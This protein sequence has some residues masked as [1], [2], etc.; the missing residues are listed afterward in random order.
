MKKILRLTY[1]YLLR[2]LPSKL[3]S[4]IHYYLVYKRSLRLSSP[5]YFSE[6]MIRI[7][8]E[9]SRYLDVLCT[10]K[11]TSK[12]LLKELGYKDYIINNLYVFN[13]IDSIYIDENHYPVIIKISNGTS[14]NI[15]IRNNADLKL[16]LS[17]LKKMFRFRHYLY[18]KEF[19][20]GMAQRR[21]LVEPFLSSYSNGLDDYKVHC[22]HGIPRFIQINYNST[23]D[24]GR[25]M[26]DESMQQ[27]EFPFASGQ[28]S[29]WIPHNISEIEE[30]MTLSRDISRYFKFIRIDFFIVDKQIKIGELTLHPMAG[31]MLRN[32]Q[33]L[34]FKWG[35]LLTID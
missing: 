11:I 8:L 28:E 15:V 29:K 33:D 23:I 17:N 30:M 16:N 21:I 14:Q 25:V 26:I 3:A 34:D 35:K 27:I 12:D 18:S 5:E 10:D 32:S 19:V 7:K 24:K 4:Q 1:K 20:Y 9:T 31:F 13:D 22:F 2:F 6:K